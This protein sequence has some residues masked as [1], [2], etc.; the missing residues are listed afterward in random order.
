[1]LE[2]TRVEK[3]IVRQ[4]D[5][6]FSMLDEFCF[7]SK[8]L[9][10]HA[11]YLIRKRYMDDGTWLRYQ[12]LDVILKEDTEYPD[13]KN[14]P[15]SSSAQQLLR[16]LDNTWSS[17]FASIRSW[18]KNPDKFK[19]KPNP[20]SYKHKTKGRCPVILTNQACRLQND[21]IVEFPKSF[22]GLRFNTKFNKRDDF[23][24]FMQCRI[25]H[26]GNHCVV[27]F[28]YTINVLEAKEDNGRYIGIDIGIDNLAAVSNNVGLPFYLVDGKGLKSINKYYNKL[29]AHYTSILIKNDSKQYSSKRLQR[30]HSKRNAK[31]NDY[32]H[33]ASR[34]IVD[35]AKENNINTI[36]IGK[37]DLWKQNS[38]MNKKT[39]QTFCQI[40]HS[41]LINMIE[42]KSE[43]YGINV[44]LQEESYTSKTSFIDD[45]YPTKLE[46]YKGKRIKRGLFRTQN[47]IVVNADCNGSLQIIKKHNKDFKCSN[48]DQAIQWMKTPIRIK[49]S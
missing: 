26:R 25:L 14:M 47:N 33:K 22:R 41:R 32:M 6:Y 45:E 44:I 18:R 17:F 23:E 8:N 38:N 28:V 2:V 5:K 39:N 4:N 31:I 43:E 29:V 42:Y 3:H 20:P 46:S 49:V 27:E 15:Y 7:L 11:N 30:L 24:K 40:P 10:N 37:N 1:M 35:F 36:V 16:T 12:D 34:F 9:Y 19:G 21:G 13:Y 48:I